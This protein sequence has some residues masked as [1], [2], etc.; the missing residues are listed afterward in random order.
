MSRR[1][2][3]ADM[4]YPKL[5][6]AE[7]SVALILSPSSTKGGLS[8]SSPKLASTRFRSAR[9]M[10]PEPST[11]PRQDSLGSGISSST[12]YAAPALAPLSSWNGAPKTATPTPAATEK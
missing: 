7:A 3:D 8:H 9:S 11:S 1:P 10:A 6:N 5:A 12:K 2:D 4:E